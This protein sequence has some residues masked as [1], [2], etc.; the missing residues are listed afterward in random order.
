M[1]S[2]EK[3][4]DEYVRVSG[5]DII[6]DQIDF[7]DTLGIQGETDFR[8]TGHAS[9]PGRPVR[10][11][12]GR[13]WR[14]SQG[15]WHTACPTAEFGNKEEYEA[16]VMMNFGDYMIFPRVL[17]RKN[18]VDANPLL[19]P[20][21]TPPGDL[22]PGVSPRNRDDDPFAVL[23]NREAKAGEIFLT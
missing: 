12:G 5:D 4:D 3:V 9:V 22:F 14:C 2:T 15:I 23:D 10:R 8:S 18:L 7:K 16:G 17:Y 1:A 13:W 6:L 21:I 19:P 20:D 11:A